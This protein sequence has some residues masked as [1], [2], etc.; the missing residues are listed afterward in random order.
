MEWSYPSTRDKVTVI[1]HVNTLKNCSS[2]FGNSI[3][4]K[5]ALLFTIMIAGMK[6]KDAY[7]LEGKL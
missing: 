2:L 4:F 5:K 6:L 3:D 7:S 1:I